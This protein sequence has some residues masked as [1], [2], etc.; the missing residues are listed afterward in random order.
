MNPRIKSFQ[1]HG[2]APRISTLSRTRGYRIKG[3]GFGDQPGKVEIEYG[4]DGKIRG[5]SIKSWS[6]TFIEIGLPVPNAKGF[7]V[8][9]NDL[10]VTRADGKR[11]KPFE[12][13]RPSFSY[14]G[15]IRPQD[16]R[17]KVR[18]AA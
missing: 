2:G 8:W 15:Y 1:Y 10:I 14:A 11:S 17:A 12:I 3:R 6:N 5:Q 16:R 4:Y 7:S 18:R 13:I 9:V